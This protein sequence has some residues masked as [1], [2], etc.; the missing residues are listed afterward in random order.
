MLLTQ[1][2]S[3]PVFNI[4][5]CVRVCSNKLCAFSNLQLRSRVRPVLCRLVFLHEGRVVWEGT[6]DEF[7]D[8]EIPIVKQFR[9][10]GLKGP[11]Q[12]V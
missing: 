8:S 3:H 5:D 12:Y 7:E 6:T 2:A 11:I 9:T 10:G 4:L 1:D